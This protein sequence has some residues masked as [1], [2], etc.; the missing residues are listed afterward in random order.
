MQFVLMTEPQLGMTYERI[1]DLARLA[2]SLGLDGFSRSDHYGFPRVESAHATDS[3]ATLAGLARD[4]ERVELC[5]LAS[6]ITFRHPAVI[7]KMA[8][9]IDEMS[10]GRLSLGVG[11]GWM[12]EEHSAFGI[13]F[14]DQSERFDRLEESLAYLH[15][16]FGRVEGPFEGRHYRLGGDR[17]SPGPTGPLSILVGGSG[18]R[19]TPRLAGTYADDYNIMGIPPADAIRSRIERARQAADAAGR[20]PAALRISVMTTAIVGSD[21]ASF[22]DNLA[23]TAAADP[24]GRSAER[25]TEVYTERGLPFGPADRARAVVAGLA[26]TGVD[27]IYLQTFG[28]YDH[29][30]LEETFA[31][32]RG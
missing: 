20:D 27:R 26:E 5:V 21:E 10:G 7:A 1:L 22:E 12:E 29:D 8:A 24:F 17:V 6:P 3:F 13:E 14:F 15:H 28:P 30:L 19:R 32:L 31:V 2:E 16:A 11:T 25:I 18:E 23:R 9:T 4:T